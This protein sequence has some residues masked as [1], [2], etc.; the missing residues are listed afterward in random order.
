MYLE[1]IVDNIQLE[2]DR[3]E[4][5][6]VLNRDDVV[7]W[8]KTIAGFANASGGEFYIGVKDKTNQLVG[9]DRKAADNERNYFN[10]QVNEHLTPR[11]QMNI[12]FIRMNGL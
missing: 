5:K 2:N 4:C 3:F 1:E 7:G 6:A 12:S 10:N 9:F 8:L 11:P